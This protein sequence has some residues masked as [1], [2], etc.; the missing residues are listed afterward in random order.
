MREK[1]IFSDWI[2]YGDTGPATMGK[3]SW[4]PAWAYKEDANNDKFGEYVKKHSEIEAVC[5]WCTKTFSF[6]AAGITALMNHSK[7]KKHKHIADGRKNRKQGQVMLVSSSSA[8]NVNNNEASQPIV[9]LK[10]PSTPQ[11]LTM[12]DKAI[13]GEII[14]VLKGVE[15][16]Y[17]YSSYGN[18]MECLRKIDPDSKVLQK[19]QLKES[20]TSYIVTHGLA[21]YFNK[22]LINSVK[23]SV[24]FT[25]GTDSAT[26]KHLGISKH[27]DLHVRF[28]DEDTGEVRDE[29]LDIHSVGHETADKQVR[30]NNLKLI[31][32]STIIVQYSVIQYYTTLHHF[33]H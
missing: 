21:P 17:S 5:T 33:W 2:G 26:F 1:S 22:R 11:V 19:M 6:E 24:G 28:W 27:V 31:E 8:D 32:C 29:F 18:L 9:Q 13:K 12:D 14:L 23:K 15:S 25:L 4:Q 20:K 3:T 16:Q 10:I 30:G 7:T